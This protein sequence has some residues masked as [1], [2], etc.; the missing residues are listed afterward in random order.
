[1]VQ[2]T[3]AWTLP[4]TLPNL[5][6][7]SG[8]GPLSASSSCIPP[9]SASS[10]ISDSAKPAT[11]NLKHESDHICPILPPST[12]KHLLHA[13]AATGLLGVSWRA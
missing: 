6:L 8:S 5:R 3:T 7:A 12:F 13:A 9:V 2:V 4:E 11:A 10:G 1:M